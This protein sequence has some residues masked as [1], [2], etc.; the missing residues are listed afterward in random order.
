MMDGIANARSKVKS[1]MRYEYAV[2]TSEENDDAM[3]VARN[4]R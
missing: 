2:K 1:M 3:E 4:G